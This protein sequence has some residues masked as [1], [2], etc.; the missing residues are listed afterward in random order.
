MRDVAIGRLLAAKGAKSWK[1]SPTGVVLRCDGKTPP[2]EQEIV[3]E[4]AKL[5][6]EEAQ[7]GKVLAKMRSLAEAAIA[8]EGKP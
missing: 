7:E 2:T 4:Q 3:A 8:A 5:A 1:I 6:A